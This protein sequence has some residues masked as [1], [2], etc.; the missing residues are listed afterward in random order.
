MLLGSKENKENVHGSEFN[1]LVTV[2]ITSFKCRRMG[3]ECGTYGTEG[4]C[5]YSVGEHNWRKRNLENMGLNGEIILIWIL[6]KYVGGGGIVWINVFPNTNKWWVFVN[7]RMNFRIP[8]NVGNFF[9]EYKE[10]VACW[11]SN[12]GPSVYSVSLRI[13]SVHL[14]LDLVKSCLLRS[15]RIKKKQRLSPNMYILCVNF[16]MFQA[17]GS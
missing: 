2:I 13:G 3:G 14:T 9:W 11:K 6:E 4:K 12:A 10:R 16:Q 7:T 17:A 15:L 1:V 5:K 8:H